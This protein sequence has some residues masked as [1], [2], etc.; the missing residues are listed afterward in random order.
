MEQISQVNNMAGVRQLSTTKISGNDKYHAPD[1]VVVEAPLELRLKRVNTSAVQLAIT[2]RTPGDDEDLVKGFLFTEG[3]IHSADD[4]HTLELDDNIATVT[5]TD[6]NTYDV[7][8]LKRRLLVSSSCGVCGKENLKSLE[9]S[10]SRLPWSSKITALYQT[11][12]QMPATMIEAQSLF[13]VT[14]G[15]HAAALFDTLGNL[16]MIREDIG[17][18]N[19]LDKLIGACL[20]DVEEPQVVVVSGRTS[21]E[22]VQKTAMLGAPILASIGPASSLAI[23]MAEEEGITLIGFLSATRINLYTGSARIVAPNH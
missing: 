20:D 15:I 1:Q 4:I 11:L 5:L 10:S 6:S 19:A 13:A 23:E 16:K 17:R 21:Y 3:I 14:G 9:Y 7:T 12:S 22:I 2:M 8:S 18:H